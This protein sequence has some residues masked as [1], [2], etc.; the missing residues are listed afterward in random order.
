MKGQEE[1]LQGKNTSA[2]A[3]GR[4]FLSPTPE[5]E[6]RME[7]SPLLDR[8]GCCFCSNSVA[9][10]PG[11]IKPS[12]EGEGEICPPR[13]GG[14][15]GAMLGRC[16]SPVLLRRG[17]QLDGTV[18]GK[19]GARRWQGFVS[20]SGKRLGSL[21][22]FLLVPLHL[23]D[24]L[25]LPALSPG[26]PAEQALQYTTLLAKEAHAGLTRS[27]GRENQLAVCRSTVNNCCK[28]L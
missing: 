2:C 24:P 23:A 25:L 3:R 10:K 12:R 5:E 26:E 6:G 14:R 22:A 17:E 4:V 11:C 13:C 27:G 28:Y 19:V 1:V 8:L 18:M 21:P 9:V 7:A 20:H 16:C 15:P